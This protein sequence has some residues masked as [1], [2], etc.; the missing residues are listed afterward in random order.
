MQTENKPSLVQVGNWVLRVRPPQQAGPPLLIVLVHGWTGDENVM[1]IFARHFPA[2]A[3]VIA[4]RGVSTAP[5]GGFG[6]LDH[7]RG[8]STPI[9]DYAPAVDSL[10][11]LIRQWSSANSLQFPKFS[12]VGFSQGAALSLSFSFFHPGQVEAIAGLSGFLP[13]GAEVY[14]DRHPLEGI[15]I[16]IAHGTQDD[17]VPIALARQSIQT[18]KQAGA[19]ITYCEDSVGHKLSKDCLQSLEAFLS[20]LPSAKQG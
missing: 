12:L 2:S 6:W 3:W 18:L 5:E 4:P 7:T 15:P 8:L 11:S 17:T 13:P 20:R 19:R 1:W 10:A 14:T 16:F 9:Q